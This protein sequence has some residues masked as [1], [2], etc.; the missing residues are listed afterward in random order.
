MPDRGQADY[1]ETRVEGRLAYD[2]DLLKLEEDIVRLPD[3]SLSRREWVRHPGAVVIL[4]FLDPQT[5]LLERQYRYPMRRHFL[6]LPAGKIEPGEEAIM[7]ARRELV[8]ECGYEAAQWRYISTLHPCIGYSNERMEF[9]V[10]NELR[11]VGR[12]LDEGEFLDVVP[13]KLESALERV[14][15]GDITDIKTVA[16]L[17]WLKSAPAALIST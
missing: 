10:A 5:I 12:R 15:C 8:E 1:T 9:F 16:G 17:L 6:E 3:G 11:H 13:M 14:W 7:T 4:A 2:G